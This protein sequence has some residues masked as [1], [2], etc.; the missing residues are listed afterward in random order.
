MRG[1]CRWLGPGSGRKGGVMS[2]CVV[3][4]D[5]LCR[6][7]IQLYVYCAGQ[8]PAHFNCIQCA[9]MLYLM[10][11]FFPLCICLWMISQI[12]TCLCVGCRT[13]I[14]LKITHF[15][16]DQCQPYIGQNGKSGAIVG[17][18]GFDT[19]CTAVC[20]RCDS[21]TACML[22]CLVPGIYVITV[23]ADDLHFRC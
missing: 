7:Q 4:P 6:L 5:S 19:I 21:S 9:I 3:S 13:S 14:C 20:N 11:I 18:R 22:C 8:I 2:V 10:D 23:I 1:V 15:Y 17:T 16:E 12:Q